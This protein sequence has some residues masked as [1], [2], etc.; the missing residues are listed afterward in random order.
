MKHNLVLISHGK[1]CE[2]LKN[3]AEMIMGQQDNIFTVSLLPSEGPED[4]RKKFFDTIEGLSEYV[5]FA[6]LMGGTPCNII[7]KEILSGKDIPL[8]AGMNLPMVISFINGELI[9]AESDF[10]VDGKNGI[11]D[12]GKV[13][14]EDLENEDE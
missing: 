6:D 14:I 13:I 11:C 4:F 3:S 10:V 7:S 8:Y 5:V 9:N 1:F 2:E 12:V